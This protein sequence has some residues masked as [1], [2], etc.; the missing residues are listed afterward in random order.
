MKTLRRR[1]KSAVWLKES[2][3]KLE[4]YA[5]FTGKTR[6]LASANVTSDNLSVA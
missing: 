2:L 3:E 6:R 4:M 1:V 5:G